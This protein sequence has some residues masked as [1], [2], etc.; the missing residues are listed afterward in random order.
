MVLVD[1]SPLRSVSKKAGPHGDI[2]STEFV[3]LRDTPRTHVAA[4]AWFVQRSSGKTDTSLKLMKLRKKKT[5]P[6]AP[7]VPD[8]EI[9]LKNGEV[10]VLH[11]LL[12][13]FTALSAETEGRYVVVPLDVSAQADADETARKVVAVLRQPGV[14][15]R[16]AEI[17]LP[18][19]AAGVLHTAARIADLR[20]AVAELR[21]HL[22]GGDHLESVYQDWCER[23]SWAFGNAY[24]ARDD[25]RHT[26]LGD[27]VD[28]LMASVAS[29][30]RDVFELKRPNMAVVSWDKTHKSWYWSSDTAKAIGQCHR[31]LDNLHRTAQ[32]GLDDHP[33]VVAY[34]PRAFV[35]IGRSADWAEGQ[36]RALHGLNARLHSITVMTYDQLLA[37]AEALLG[38]FAV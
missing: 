12:H 7:A 5:A 15:A 19:D 23:Y 3:V 22:D 29:G 10:A 4:R 26:A 16:L 13:H 27:Q 20:T 32:K 17:G 6:P 33:E 34:H 25:V 38:T 31:Y 1:D 30:L 8:D 9:T 21:E 14:A 18:A 28:L 35:V 11:E 2:G 24:V 36:H 37:Q